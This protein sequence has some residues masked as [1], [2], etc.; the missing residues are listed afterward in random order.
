MKVRH[1]IRTIRTFKRHVYDGRGVYL[2]STPDEPTTCKQCLS[3][4][5]R[6]RRESG[7]L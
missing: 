5:K 7:T 1:E 6:A 4:K 3:A 2:V